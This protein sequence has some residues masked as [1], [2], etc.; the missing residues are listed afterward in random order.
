MRF[1][2][3]HTTRYDYSAPASESFAELRL[4]ARTN[5]SQRVIDRQLTITPNAQ[6]DHYTDYFGNKVE[7]FSIPH[8]HDQLLVKAET[9]VETLESQPPDEML[10]V[11]IG[12]ARQIYNSTLYQL[13]EYLQPSIYVPFDQHRRIRKKFFR[14]AESI[15]ESLLGLNAW[16]FKNFEYQSGSSDISTPVKEIVATRRGV[17]QDFAHLMLAIL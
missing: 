15:R 13:F 4:W 2:V 17:C 5:H 12:E 3:S 9:E 1:R 8:R 10:D 14:Q 16:I 7:F 11:A 6:V